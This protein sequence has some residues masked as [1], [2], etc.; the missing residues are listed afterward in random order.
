[1]WQLYSFC[2]Y[3]FSFSLTTWE[4]A[5]FGNSK[6]KKIAD[7]KKIGFAS[8]SRK[9]LIRKQPLQVICIKL[10]LETSTNFTGNHLC[11]SHFTKKNLKQRCFPVKF[12]KTLRTSISRNI[13][14]QLLLLIFIEY[15]CKITY[16]IGPISYLLFVT[17][18]IFLSLQ[19]ILMWRWE[20]LSFVYDILCSIFFVFFVFRRCFFFF[21]IPFLMPAFWIIG[22]F[23][24]FDFCRKLIVSGVVNSNTWNKN[25]FLKKEKRKK[26]RKMMYINH[27]I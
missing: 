1:M 7:N 20:G 18:L 14:G 5:I 16:F 24:F 10:F 13:W 2:N 19:K 12:A 25:L 21:F 27:W 26:F 9:C 4:R 11:W 3:S 15:S 17:I 22:I 8:I 23:G 6:N